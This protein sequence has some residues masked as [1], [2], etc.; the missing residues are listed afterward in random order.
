MGGG[1]ETVRSAQVIGLSK[2]FGKL[3]LQKCWSLQDI[4]ETQCEQ[5]C[6]KCISSFP[7]PY[8]FSMPVLYG[9][10]WRL[11]SQTPDTVQDLPE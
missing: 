7:K 2:E 9:Y 10:P 11:L 5:Q 1:S 3:F 6:E 8:Y 4:Y